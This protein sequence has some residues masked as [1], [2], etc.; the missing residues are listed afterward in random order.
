MTKLYW[1]KIWKR[2]SSWKNVGRNHFYLFVKTISPWRDLWAEGHNLS[3][4]SLSCRQPLHYAT[5]TN[6]GSNRNGIS[7]RTV[8]I[9]YPCFSSVAILYTMLL[10]ALLCFL[11][12]FIL[13]IYLSCI[14]ISMISF[15]PSDKHGILRIIL[16]SIYKKCRAKKE[17]CDGF[18]LI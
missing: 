6:E 5:D 17:N 18:K 7:N 3:L 8:A 16:E 9:R 4:V 12:M 2:N 10:Q 11:I 13:L 14:S 15:F 1:F